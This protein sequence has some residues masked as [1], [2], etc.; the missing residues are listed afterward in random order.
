MQVNKLKEQSKVKSL[1]AL[2]GV[3]C[4]GVFLFHAG[5][6]VSWA[7]LGVSVFF[8]LSGFLLM[9][10]GKSST[11]SIRS[12][13]IYTIQKLRR[14][15]VLHIVT[16]VSTIIFYIIADV[17]K[18]GSKMVVDIVFNILLIQS[19]IPFSDVNT[20]LNG[21]AWFLST[22]SFLYF[23]FPFIKKAIEK[24]K[25]VF[26]IICPVLIII[27]QVL[28]CIPMLLLFKG[29][30]RTYVWFMYCNPLFRV[31]DFI[32]GCCLSKLVDYL[33]EIHLSYILISIC[34]ILV[35][36]VSIVVI[37]W[38]K[39]ND[40]GTLF[41]Q[42]M[43]NWTSG[44]LILAS[45]WVVIF[46]LRGGIISFIFDN[47]LIRLVG[48]LSPYIFLIHY[49]VVRAAYYSKWFTLFPSGV[50]IIALLL[51][52]ICLAF[53][54]RFVENWLVKSSSGSKI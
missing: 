49:I 6:S 42:A 50:R 5:A 10:Y 9:K 28:S 48:D 19:W 2:R 52:T 4:I 47:C 8:V 7:E 22:M 14:L 27:I 38:L 39:T 30:G 37:H 29:G 53:L 20:S 36:Y 33:K 44:Y 46:Y 11:V 21:V 41:V 3:S 25:T 23:L 43:K 1:Q 51:I 18:I 40:E 34:E 17:E 15:Y 16:M 32:V 45:I 12:S 24:K 35:L 31:G 26:L 13:F 54:Y